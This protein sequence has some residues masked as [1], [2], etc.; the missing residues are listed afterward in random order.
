MASKEG[1]VLGWVIGLFIVIPILITATSTWFFCRS[2]RTAT[3]AGAKAVAKRVPDDCPKGSACA[4]AVGALEAAGGAD[5]AAL[6]GALADPSWLDKLPP[7]ATATAQEKGQWYLRSLLGV[8]PA[9]LEELRAAPFEWRIA[10]TTTALDGSTAKVT[11]EF[12]NLP[13]QAEERSA[14]LNLRRVDGAWKLAP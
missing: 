8:P 3:S 14:T 1:S 9:S 13:G 4:V 6:R 12:R 5:S 7:A 11:V 2:M 10:G